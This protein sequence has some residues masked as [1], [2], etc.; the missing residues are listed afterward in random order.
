MKV[1]KVKNYNYKIWDGKLGKY[2][3]DT[4]RVGMVKDVFGYIPNGYIEYVPNRIFDRKKYPE[5]YN[6]FGKYYMP[7]ENEVELYTNKHLIMKKSKKRV[8]KCIFLLI[9][10]IIFIIMITMWR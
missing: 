7:T 8:Y 2:V 4:T 10:I 9:F 5:L 6:L 1:I 3:V